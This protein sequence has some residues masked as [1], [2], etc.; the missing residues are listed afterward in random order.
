MGA[1]IP[2]RKSRGLPAATQQQ[3]EALREARRKLAECWSLR[4]ESRRI[5]RDYEARQRAIE[6]L[7]AG[8]PT[9]AERA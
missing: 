6:R 9:D 2:F 7:L 4:A 1:I 3:S 5:Q 8:I